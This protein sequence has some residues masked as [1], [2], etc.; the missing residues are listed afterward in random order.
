MRREII[1]EI[2]D[3]IYLM[4]E[5]DSS[6]FQV[7]EPPV[8]TIYIP[9]HRTERAGRRSEWDRIEFKDL[10]KQARHELAEHWSKRDA[11]GILERLDYIESDEDLPLWLGEEKGLAFLVDPD[12]CRV[13]KM[14]TE[15]EAKVVVGDK[16]YMD[17]ILDEAEAEQAERFKLLL[18][19]S[20]FFALLDGDAHGVHYEPLPDSVAQY[21]AEMYPAFS[22][23]TTALDYYSLEGHTS[24]YHDHKSR[25]DV[26]KEEQKKFF[27]HVNKVLNDQLLRNYQNPVILVTA[28]EHVHMFKEVCTVD[29]YPKIIEKDPR[30]LTGKQLHEDALKLLGRK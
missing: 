22:G 21:F 4:D 19:N 1:R 2:A 18:L 23:N 24:P 25:N 29:L 16:Y 9:V 27:R 12:K 7:Q 28:P 10:V 5:I 3:S 8:V 15:P 11:H 30:G 20:D 6:E 17:P 14:H 26:S 13:Y